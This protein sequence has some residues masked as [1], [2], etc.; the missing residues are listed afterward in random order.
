M[1]DSPRKEIISGKGAKGAK[2]N[3]N[4]AYFASLRETYACFSPR[5]QDATAARKQHMPDVPSSYPLSPVFL[6]RGLG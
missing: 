4:L 2:K 1:F 5:R 3:K 6:G